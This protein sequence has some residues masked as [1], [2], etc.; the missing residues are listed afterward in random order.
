M[1]GQDLR[2]HFEA[3]I[4]EGLDENLVQDWFDNARFT[5]NQQHAFIAYVCRLPNGI[6][7][8][9]S[10][11][12]AGKSTLIARLAMPYLLQNAL[13]L[14]EQSALLSPSSKQEMSFHRHHGDVRDCR[15]FQRIVGMEYVNQPLDIPQ[16]VLD[17]EADPSIAIG[18]SLA[19]IDLIAEV[20]HL[21]CLLIDSN[22]FGLDDI[23]IVVFH[24]SQAEMYRQAL[25]YYTP[26]GEI[27]RSISAGLESR[28][29][30]LFRVGRATSL[31]SISL[32]ASS[33]LGLSLCP[34]ALMLL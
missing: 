10:V 8:L 25:D 15:D 23:V 5:P 31:L 21:I 13:E 1:Q 2:T 18:A 19:N 32:Q 16:L 12:E 17:V 6:G 30:T 34:I 26:I 27:L 28:Q 11:L 3:D 4:Y 33:C 7:L 29:L 14:L 9:Q 22:E 20:M 24:R